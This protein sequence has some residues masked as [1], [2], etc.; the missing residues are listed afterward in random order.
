MK[1]PPKNRNTEAE[2]L[3]ASACDAFGFFR[4]VSFFVKDRAG[5][6]I[7]ANKDNLW[8]SGRRVCL[9][10]NLPSLIAAPSGGLDRHGHFEDPV[11]NAI[12]GQRKGEGSIE[13][14]KIR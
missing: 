11:V 1:S 2:A 6:F 3:L 5:G 10:E 8:T 9:S 4:D 12:A 13:A 7:A 14:R